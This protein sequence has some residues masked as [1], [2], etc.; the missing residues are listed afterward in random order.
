M[1]EGEI[2]HEHLLVFARTEGERPSR[3]AKHT[4]VMR[5]RENKPVQTVDWFLRASALRNGGVRAICRR[6]FS[7]IPPG[8]MRDRGQDRPTRGSR[9]RRGP[10]PWAYVAGRHLRAS[11]RGRS[12]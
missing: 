10:W 4:Y 11:F 12:F 8:A 7:A 1:T 9:E 6:R 3:H 5:R 2:K